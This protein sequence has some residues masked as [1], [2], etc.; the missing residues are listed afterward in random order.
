MNDKRS[1]PR[2]VV[3]LTI[4][5]HINGK[6]IEAKIIDLTVEGLSME[7]DTTLEKDAIA[8]IKI[9]QNKEVK[10]NELKIKIIR[11]LA[12][13]RKPSKYHIVARFIEP[14]DEFLMDVLALVH[15]SGPK[16]DRRGTI[17]GGR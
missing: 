8:K 10:N 5:V 1:F 13:E 3:D 16:K 2:S 4:Q 7:L 15:D 14:N 11:S 17:Y 9:L 6:W 12:I